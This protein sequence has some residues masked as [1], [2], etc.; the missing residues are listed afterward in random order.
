MSAVERET[1]H[2]ARV[3]TAPRTDWTREEVEALFALPFNDLLYTAQW[4]HRQVF[5]P[6]AV[7]VST[8]LSIKTG[9]CPEDC[10]YCPQSIR[11]TTGVAAEPL[12]E[13]ARVRECAARAKAAGATRFCMGAAYRSPKARALEAIA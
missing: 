8:L 1:G 11:Y 4:V 2:G 12:M 13:L 5:D 10:A 9:A 3:T 7:Q 6:C